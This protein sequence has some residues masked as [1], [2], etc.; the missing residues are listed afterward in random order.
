MESMLR[1]EGLILGERRLR[2]ELGVLGGG[3]EH[4]RA[5]LKHAGVS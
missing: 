3:M 2:M 4:W 5:I 1:W